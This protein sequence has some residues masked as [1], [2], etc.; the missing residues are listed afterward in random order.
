MRPPTYT[1]LLILL[2]LASFLPLTLAHPSH[3]AP[4]PSS[5][6]TAL[7]RRVEPDR[8]LTDCT[9][10]RSA[11]DL[12]GN[13]AGWAFQQSFCVRD[14]SWSSPR[15]F[16]KYRIDC[17]APGVPS[18]LQ[19]P[20]SWLHTAYNIAECAPTQICVDGP[21]TPPDPGLVHLSWYKVHGTAY[22]VDQ[23]RFVHLSQDGLQVLGQ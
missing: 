5:P 6:P 4:L 12:G 8:P 16:R 10:G 23:Q 18:M 2:H 11:H 3:P 7:T 9:E 13:H 17:R 21:Y 14:S 22:C 1:S 19:G 20:V 15:H